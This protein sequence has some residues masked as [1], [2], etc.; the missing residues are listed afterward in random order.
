MPSGKAVLMENLL[1]PWALSWAFGH[2]RPKNPPH[3][4]EKEGE[5]P[6]YFSW[7]SCLSF[8]FPL[9]GLLCTLEGPTVMTA[10]AT[11]LPSP[12]PQWG[13]QCSQ[14]GRSLSSQ[15]S[16]LGNCGTGHI[17]CQHLCAG[18]GVAGRKRRKAIGSALWHWGC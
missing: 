18:L 11:F 1:A 12:A 17:G 10:T 6:A 4:L 16:S 3:H 9:S 15:S 8:H 2:G 13:S 14:P 7:Q 5:L